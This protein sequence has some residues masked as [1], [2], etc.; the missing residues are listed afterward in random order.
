MAGL[1]TRLNKPCYVLHANAGASLETLW[2]AHKGGLLA[3]AGGG[4]PQA[5]AKA[6]KL[7]DWHIANLEVGC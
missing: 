4:D 2:D 5:A 3:E 7:F 6:R 1:A